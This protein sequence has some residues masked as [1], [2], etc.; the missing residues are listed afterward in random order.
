MDYIKEYRKFVNS[1]YF[2]EAIRITI[3]ITLP[4]I[5]CNYF[6]RLQT[7]LILSLGALAVSTS[8]IPGPIGQRRNGMLA[9]I[10]LIFLI[11]LIT[12][13]INQ[14]HI[15]LGF[16]ILLFCFML[17]MIGVYGARVNAVGFAGM[18]IM[19]I[20]LDLHMENSQVLMHSVTLV[21]G[22][23]WY[24]ILSLALFGVRPYKVI[25]Q[26]LGD[27]IISIGD[28]FATRALFYDK[29]ADYDSIYKRLMEQQQQ[30]EDKQSLLRE[31][32]FKSRSIVK[33]STITSRT[34]L[35]IFLESIDLFEKA[36]ATFYNYQSMHKRFDES[37]ILEDF[38]RVIDVIVDE[39]HLIGLAVQSGRPTRASRRLNNELR[40]LKE[41]FENFANDYRKPESFDAIVNMRKLLQSVEDI[42]LRIYTLHHY[43]R[44]DIKKVQKYKLSDDYQYFVNKTDLN[45]QTLKENLSLKSN[46]FRHSIRVTIACLLGYIVAHAL[47]LQYSYWV[48]L[49]IIVIL[50]PTY[51]VTRQRNYH[52]LI[53]TFIGALIGLGLLFIIPT[54]NGK[55]AAMIVL[56][57]ITYSFMRTRYLVSVIFMTAYVMIYFYLLNSH[58]FYEI[59]KSRLIDTTVGSIIALTAAYVLVP[60][61]ERRQISTYMVKAL[62][63]TKAY[64]ETVAGIFATGQLNERDYNIRRKDAFIEQANLSGGF[65]RMMNEPKSK[66]GDIKR[67]H[68]M[69]VLVYTL[70]SH[71]VSL[72]A[73]TKGFSNVFPHEDFSAIKD[74]IIADLNESI[75]LIE[76]KG[77]EIQE[78][79]HNDAPM[80]L[81]HELNE[82]IEKRRRELQQGII[83]TET[84]K[85]LTTFKPVA[86]QFLFISRIAEDI[87]KLAKRFASN[88]M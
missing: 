34:L 59:F 12:G 83:D 7:G 15:L 55:F 11:S 6:D 43:T 49:T 3:G 80:E 13:F 64:F 78:S 77:K 85:M 33:E 61:W 39:L 16:E 76:N 69:V 32:M 63:A 21:A 67:I 22:G 82:L 44:Y 53:G 58:H 86:D 2:N 57:I 52:R 38:R 10:G 68:Q 56:M 20:N 74:D 9:S 28:Y 29:N 60:S 27:C 45:I 84:R 65:T 26:A 25:Q 36:A 54:Q 88:G 30:I 73:M 66:Q 5:V 41:R 50:K 42:T 51:S 46:T 14:Y 87:K 47:K 8:D 17:S 40:V 62:I 75:S 19:V 18:L 23:C 48:L 72:A 1:Y 4:V 81:K 37:G 71:I 35:V 31:M 70:N 79:K 24:M